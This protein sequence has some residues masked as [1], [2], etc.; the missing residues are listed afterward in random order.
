MNTK[1]N[2]ITEQSEVRLYL[3]KPIYFFLCISCR[4]FVFWYLPQV[5]YKNPNVQ[6]IAFK[7]MTPTPFIRCFYGEYI[8][9]FRALL[10]K[11]DFRGWETHVD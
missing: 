11:F 2:A 5:Q 1:Q 6:V 8:D 4:D 9:F 10:F 7:N 3:C